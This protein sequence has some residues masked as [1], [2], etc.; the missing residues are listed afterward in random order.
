MELSGQLHA[1]VSEPTEPTENEV[2][3]AESSTGR[4]KILSLSLT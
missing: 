3:G 4:E 1:A 2:G